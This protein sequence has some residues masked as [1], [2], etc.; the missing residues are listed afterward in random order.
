MAPETIAQ[1]IEAALLAS[2]GPL[3]V[4]NLFRLFTLGELDEEEGRKQI[5]TALETLQDACDGRGVTLQKVS[6]GYRYQTR[7]DLSP[8][9]SRLWEEKPPRYTRALL[10]TLA[11]VAYKQ[12]VTRGDIEQVRGVSVSQ[13]I[14]RTLLERDWIRVVGQREAPGRPSMYG[15][16]KAFLDYFNLNKLEELPPL[17][18]IK[19]MI[20]PTLVA[21]DNAGQ[22][23]DA[24]P[25]E[26]SDAA[27]DPA[28][29]ETSP[30][31]TV[32]HEVAASEAEGMDAPAEEALATEHLLAESSQTE[33]TGDAEPE[34]HS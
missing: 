17:E 6:S 1:I 14:M 26:T 18:E 13:N 3:T 31:G 34:T 7:Q 29:G 8:W 16:T 33:A 19:A 23:D 25:S 11:L 15:T 32:V 20:E 4:D 9:V 2:E 27:A 24:V 28:S 21:N 12:P 22:T 10:E 5:R 30:D